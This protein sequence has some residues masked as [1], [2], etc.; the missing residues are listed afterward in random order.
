LQQTKETSPSWPPISS[1][2]SPST[3]RLRRDALKGK[4]ITFTASFE[5]EGT[6]VN[7]VYVAG[8]PLPFDITDPT[9][10]DVLI[11]IELSE[12]PEI[13][14]GDPN[15]RFGSE[16]GVEQLRGRWTSDGTTGTIHVPGAQM[17]AFLLAAFGPTGVIPEGL[18]PVP[19][20]FSDL[21]VTVDIATG[22]AADPVS[23]ILDPLGD[24]EGEFLQEVNTTGGPYSSGLG[25]I[26]GSVTGFDTVSSFGGNLDLFCTDQ[27]SQLG[28]SACGLGP[29]G[30]AFVP[31]S[32]YDPS[33]GLV[34]MT[35]PL[36]LGTSVVF[37]TLGDARLLEGGNSVTTA[38]DTDADGVE[39]S[40]DNCP[41]VKNAAHMTPTDCNGD[42]DTTDPGEGTGE[43]CDQDGDGVGDPC[44]SCRRIA[45][46]RTVPAPDKH[47]TTGDQPDDDLDGVGNQCDIDFT[48]GAGDFFGNVTDLLRFLEAFGKQITASTCPD[49]DNNPA[50]ACVRY[51]LTVEGDV[52]NVN[53][54]LVVIS[55]ALFG[56]SS[57]S[58]GCAADDDATVRC[59]LGCQSGTSAAPCPTL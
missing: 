17:E 16:L 28:G 56:Q 54:L 3:L 36:T 4:L 26:P 18:I 15:A 39:D 31:S 50:G 48:E 13:L 30:S 53:D 1:A 24:K 10:R 29:L 11:D 41:T 19:G 55:P 14:G 51:D 7:V 34:N 33:T 40:A 22:N 2:S 9:E 42:S 25:S 27:F 8:I 37:S 45:N 47:R 5:E 38:V 57:S 46:P 35:G 20:S 21:V 43:Q 44:D 12:N 52:V 58:Q 59:P 6:I 23:G 32:P 49:P